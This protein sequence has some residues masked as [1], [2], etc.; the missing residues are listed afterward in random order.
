SV[1]PERSSLDGRKTVQWR[2]GDDRKI[3]AAA[4]RGLPQCARRQRSQLRKKADE[5][6]ATPL[7]DSSGLF[8]G[9]YPG[10]LQRLS[11]FLPSKL[12]KIGSPLACHSVFGRRE[13]DVMKCSICW[14]EI[15]GSSRKSARVPVS[16]RSASRTEK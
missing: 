10:N 2:R 14:G 5:T 8:R 1:F 6:L 11:H 15:R 9:K 12:P 4:P 16:A 3:A 7:I 13:G